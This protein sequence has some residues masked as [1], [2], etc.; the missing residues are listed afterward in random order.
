MSTAFALTWDYRCPFARIGHDLVL[1]GLADG[2]DWD[3]TF[4]AF[5]LDQSHVAD[6]APPVWDE[7]ERYP[8]LVANL[9]GIAV[10]D[11]DRSAF[12]RVHAALFSARH[13]QALDLRDRAIVGKVLDEAGVDG[14][15]ILSE[16]D[17]GWPLEVLRRE[18]TEA[19]DRWQVF[20]VPTFIVGD[21][22]V[23]VRLT[24]RAESASDATSSV[25]RVL[26]MIS[27]WPELNE[28]KH[29]SLS[30]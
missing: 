5:S 27:A 3:V 9:A 15:G 2:A 25:E 11:R 18:H 24:R 12:P 20:G 13:E 29:T 17:A 28:F 1:N 26:Q 30:N 6:D 21:S 10:R 19:V 7:P 14:A 22:A 16:V 4:R 23:F 8:G